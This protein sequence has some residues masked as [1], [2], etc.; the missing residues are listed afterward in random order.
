M[1]RRHY[2]AAAGTLSVTVLAGCSSEDNG[3]PG[4]ITDGSVPSTTQ[5]STPTQT[6]ARTASEAVEKAT[7]GSGASTETPIVDTPSTELSGDDYQVMFEEF[8][9]SEGISVEEVA[10]EGDRAQIDYTMLATTQSEI[11]EEM[12]TVSGAYA[13]LVDDGW[14]TSGLDAT[15]LAS[16]GSVAGTFSLE[17]DM[18][19]AFANGEISNEEFGQTLIES[20]EVNGTSSGGNNGSSEQGA[21]EILEHG[22]YQEEYSEGVRGIAQNTTDTTLDYAEVTIVF[23]DADGVQVGDSIDNTTNLAAGR[24]WQFDLPFLGNDWS[25]VADYE[26]ATDASVY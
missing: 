3:A 23:L 8:L 21:L 7:T 16:D 17:A 4:D 24:K 15:I 2:L 10:V 13:A 6:A 20:L 26:L 19:Q 9:Q 5:P 11:V 25:A 14:Q 1:N 12:G 18:A 22:P